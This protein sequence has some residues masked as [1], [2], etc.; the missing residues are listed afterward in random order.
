MR[1]TGN[2]YW[3]MEALLAVAATGAFAQTIN[4]TNTVGGSWQEAGNW[5][6][7]TVPAGAGVVANFNAVGTYTV[8]LN[9]NATVDRLDGS[10]ANVHLTF[11]ANGY[12]FDNLLNTTTAGN[13]GMLFA[14]SGSATVIT[15]QVTL[16]SS[17]PGGVL[18]VNRMR[19]GS[20]SRPASVTMTGANLTVEMDGTTGDNS[21][22]YHANG[23]TVMSG[24][25]RVNATRALLFGGGSQTVH[26]N[27][28]WLITDPGTVVS[29]SY[30]SAVYIGK[31]SA[32][33]PTAIITNGAV[34]TTPPGTFRVA[35]GG[36]SG[37]SY[38]TNANARLIVTGAGSFVDSL[39]LSVSEFAGNGTLTRDGYNGTGGGFVV[40]ENGGTIT[41]RSGINVG[42][43]Y[44]GAT[45][46]P[47][48]VYTYTNANAYGEI[49]V[50]GTGSAVRGSGSVQIGRACQGAIYVLDGGL[51]DT[52]PGANIEIARAT[53]P[54][55][56]GSGLPEYTNTMAYG[57]LVVSNAGSTVKCRAVLVG[58]A[59][60]ANE[61]YGYGDVVVADG[62][63][64][65]TVNT[66]DGI[67]LKP[68]C[69]LTISDA[70]VESQKLSMNSNSTLRVELGARGHGQSY[71]KLRGNLELNYQNLTGPR[72]LE[73]G[74][75]DSFAAAN[76]ETI[77][78]AEFAARTGNPFANAADGDI[79]DLGKWRFK[80]SETATNI[81]LRVMTRGTLI[82]VL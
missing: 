7:G 9:G 44:N 12:T 25:V 13:E 40:V 8:T 21:F 10:Y 37:T 63:E 38:N 32:G 4:W 58:G 76:G 79:I 19:Y 82:R 47:T 73:I 78:V 34:L 52:A 56:A 31:S 77:A 50:R 67:Y 15:Q 26:P 64:L 60:T 42:R 41:N 69:G 6:P 53:Y 62:A 75:L 18:R 36:D 55:N 29:N 66:S 72:Y 49:V 45:N 57:L 23:T 65:L 81:T 1:M 71:L 51:F 61:T 74:A 5:N 17:Q 27:N 22:N 30:G 16:T 68:R 28:L 59:W 20:V 80:Y 46:T 54:A 35:Q 2:R 24:G 43:A 14:Y 48:V 3:A 11:D 33:M 39:Y 70:F